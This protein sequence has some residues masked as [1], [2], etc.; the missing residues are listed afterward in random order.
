MTLIVQPPQ[1]I[2]CD[3]DASPS[4]VAHVYD[5]ASY[6][7]ESMKRFSWRLMFIGAKLSPGCRTKVRK[8]SLCWSG[9]YR[10][11]CLTEASQSQLVE[12]NTIICYLLVGAHL[13]Y[14]MATNLS[15]ATLIEPAMHSVHVFSNNHIELENSRVWSRSLKDLFKHWKWKRTW[16]FAEKHLE[17]AWVA[18]SG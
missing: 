14:A 7:G 18:W 8:E 16:F 12:L 13:R 2:F 5:R 11:D 9:T 3:S 15:S 4:S 1:S 6:R 17:G 10:C